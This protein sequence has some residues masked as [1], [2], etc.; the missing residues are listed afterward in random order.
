M[1][2]LSRV[3]CHIQAD[4]F[5]WL[6]HSCQ[7]WSSLVLWALGCW[8]VISGI[9]CSVE[10]DSQVEGCRY[11]SKHK[12]DSNVA[13]LFVMCTSSSPT[14]RLWHMKMKYSI[15]DLAMIHPYTSKCHSLKKGCTCYFGSKKK[16]NA[17]S[18]FS[19][20]NFSAHMQSSRLLMSNTN[21]RRTHHPMWSQG[22][23]VSLFHW[24]FSKVTSMIRLYKITGWGK[25]GPKID[26]TYPLCSGR[27]V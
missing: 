27:A 12:S 26:L 18:L 3:S 5:S 14:A 2:S 19:D 9:L 1:C 4:K 11:C 8:L 17:N 24:S 10:S 15:S 7:L 6:W 22:L 23:A 25:K 16:S 21:L 13:V 20:W